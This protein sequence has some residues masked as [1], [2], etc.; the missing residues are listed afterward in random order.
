MTR[1]AEDR[2][3]VAI[4]LGWRMAELC[5]LNVEYDEPR[6]RTCDLLPSRNS[7]SR[8]DRLELEVL[9]AAGAV[10]RLGI[11]LPEEQ[12][13]QVRALAERAAADKGARAEFR[14][15][16]ERCHVA[17]NKQ[18]WMRD[19]AEGR[20]YELGITLS[21]TYNRIFRAYQGDEQTPRDEWQAVFDEARITAL[22]KH[23][24][25]LQSRLDPGAVAV[26]RD[27]LKAWE[28]RVQNALAAGY[29]V[30]SADDSMQLR[31]QTA[32]W[33]QLLTGDK[34]PEAFLE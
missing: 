31:R 26:V 7:F 30:P 22:N 18:L 1:S 19:E 25:N 20:A 8:H 9:A 15:Q 13:D 23:L 28:E 33:R 2:V 4:D 24:D 32:V 16:L 5:A 12:L 21:D 29:D 27:H 11:G 6:E 17:L 10:R 3:A 34:Q 14:D